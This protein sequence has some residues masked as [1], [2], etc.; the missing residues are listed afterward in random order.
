M[1]VDLRKVYDTVEYDFLL[2][3]LKLFGFPR[4]F[5]LWIQE[6]VTMCSF[7]M[8]LNGNIHGFFQGSH[9]LRQGDPMSTY[10]FLLVIELNFAND[11][12]LFSSADQTSIGVFKRG[13]QLFASLSGLCTNP[14]KSQLIILKSAFNN[15]DMLLQSVGYQKGILPV[16]YLGL[17]L[18]SSR[19]TLSDVSRCSRKLRKGSM[20]GK[21]SVIIC[22]KDFCFSHRKSKSD[23]TQASPGIPLAT[24]TDLDLPLDK[25]NLGPKKKLLVL[26]LGGLLVHRVHVR[27]KASIRGLRPDVLH[28]KFLVFKRPFCTEFL[29]FCFERFEV[30][31][32][33]SAMNHNIGALLT[34]ITGGK[35]SKF[36]FVRVSIAL[37]HAGPNGELRKFLD[38]LAD[39]KDVPSYVKDHRIG[40]PAITPSHPDWSYYATIVSH[41]EKKGEAEKS[42]E[43]SDDE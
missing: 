17:P 15:R 28:G 18:T 25:L 2:A 42:A 11:L 38:G 32:W 12:S 3:T 4:Q 40:Q 30:G 39:A 7:S 33:S 41:L 43:T 19:L 31:L 10:L 26:C 21:D 20:G 16:K 5:I 35:G 13:L 6:C 27:D 1:N 14:N 23:K 37:T 24:A 29:K 22:G 36:L 9:G 8:S 34:E